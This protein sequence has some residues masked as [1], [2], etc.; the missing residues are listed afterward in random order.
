MNE[1]EL[2][3]YTVCFHSRGIVVVLQAEGEVVVVL[4]G[5]RALRDLAQVVPVAVGAGGV[6]AAVGTGGGGG[7]GVRGQV[8]VVERV[9]RLK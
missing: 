1:N 3:S 5:V 9:V 8:R 7:G 6:A 4:V 2:A